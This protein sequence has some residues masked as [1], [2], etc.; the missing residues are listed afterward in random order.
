MKRLL[1]LAL[2]A[3]GIASPCLAQCGKPGSGGWHSDCTPKTPPIK[4]ISRTTMTA[5]PNPVVSGN[6]V[7]LK[8]TVSSPS[9]TPTGAVTFED[10]GVAIAGAVN[11]SGGVA[12]L[13]YTAPAAGSYP[14]TANYSGFGNWAPSASQPL[15][16]VVTATGSGNPTG[17]A[18]SSCGDLIASGTYYLSQNVSSPG[19]CFFIDANNI[20]LNLNGKTATYGTAGGTMAT[21][22][23]LLADS[24][25]NQYSLAESGTTSNHSGFV[26]YGGS[27]VASPDA[28]PGSRGIWTGCNTNEMTPAPVIH[29]LTISTTGEDAIPIFG[30][31][32][33]SGWQI[34][35]N[36]IA[37]NGGVTSSRYDF[38]G[39]AIW[40][41]DNLDY[42]GTT[43]DAI[44]NNK[45]TA[46]P[47]GGIFDDHQNAVIGPSNDI[48]FDS[49]YAN[50]YCVIDYSGDGQIIKNNNCHPE[51]GRGFDVESAN[52]QVL[53]NTITV[54]E[55]PQDA[56]YNGCEEGG[57]DGIRTRCN[58]SACTQGGNNNP[59][60]PNGVVI[61]GNTIDVVA[62]T[63][64]AVGL[65]FTALISTNSIT[66]SGNTV[67]TSGPGNLTNP[68]Y[69]V[70]F[71]GDEGAALT[72]TGNTFSAK[73]ANWNV[74]WDGASEVISGAQSYTGTAVYSL[75]DDNGY[76]G[77]T[78]Q[79]GPTF[80]QS[81]D[82]ANASAGT[83][84]CGPWA[85]GPA[86]FGSMSKTCNGQ[87]EGVKREVVRHAAVIDSAR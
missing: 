77:G 43:A 61:Q 42:L 21:P 46:A 86:Q 76:Q 41:G 80:A 22:G 30:D 33:Q 40:L 35:N 38:L 63:C 87:N 75:F 26:V 12:T 54:T 49:F 31:G 64:S 10:G 4:T 39:Y 11:L 2:V 16:I 20:T 3:C 18:L 72:F 83:I 74:D 14:I 9:G 23:I 19:T 62:G 55:L 8:A 57:A 1:L 68:D 28:A 47:Q 82:I 84:S 29:D 48:T 36:T 7:V 27:L 25:Y 34:Y 13:N 24:W 78:A 60:A 44:Y 66:I 53:D 37:Y 69:D 58:N 67:T 65:R 71:D 17:T 6:V 50:D 85:A 51:S 32:A 52:V 56:E 79:G 73:Y 70:S 15:T 59:T 5:T 45:I 81:I